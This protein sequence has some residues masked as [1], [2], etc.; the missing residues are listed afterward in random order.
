M[1]PVALGEK[2]IHVNNILNRYSRF[3]HLYCILQGIFSQ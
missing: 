1:P 2:H 3:L